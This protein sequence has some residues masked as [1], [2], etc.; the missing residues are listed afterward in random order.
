MPKYHKLQR[1]ACLA[2]FVVSSVISCYQYHTNA[3]IIAG[4]SLIGVIAYDIVCYLKDKNA[5]KDFTAQVKEL[6]EKLEVTSQHVKEMKDDVSVAKLANS[7]R[8]G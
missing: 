3:V 6:Q 1:G 8:R 2:L 4:L 5:P 7:F